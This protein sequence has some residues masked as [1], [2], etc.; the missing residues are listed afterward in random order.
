MGRGRPKSNRFSLSSLKGL[1]D[2]IREI[3]R[4][5][6]I[7]G[8]GYH[9]LTKHPGLY[10]ALYHHGISQKKLISRLGLDASYSKHRFKT[11]RSRS[12]AGVVIRRWDWPRILRVVS[13][14]RK[15]IGHLPPA[16]WFQRNKLGGLVQSVYSLGMSWGDLRDHF[17]DET[18]STFF[19]SRNGMRWRSRA[20]AGFS[21]YLHSRGVQ[22]E[23]GQRYPTAYADFAQ[24]AFGQYDVRLKS[25]RGKWIDV[26]IWGDKPL[27]HNPVGYAR[28]RRQK[29]AFNRKFNRNFLGLQYQDCYSDTALKKLLS[30]HIGIRKPLKSRFLKA[31]DPHIE[32]AHWSNV[33][34]LVATCQKIADLQ[35]DGK[36]PSEEWLRKRG[37]FANRTGVSYNTVS[38][39]I[40]HWVGGIRKLRELM[41]QPENSTLRW[42]RESALRELARWFKQY[43]LS[44]VTI[45]NEV[46][47]GERT[48]AR[49]ELE[50]GRK[51]NT[52]VTVYA[53]GMLKACTKL[54]LPAGFEVW[55]RTRALSELKIWIKTYGKA[56]AAVKHMALKGKMNVDRKELNRGL[57]I[58]SAVYKHVGSMSK[59]IERVS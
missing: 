16:A 33:D 55:S 34:E 51:I 58:N 10:F 37:K 8:L 26:E 12:K 7:Q 29:E 57:R 31:Y 54:G 53:G 20:E 15:R 32:T 48:L 47:R 14:E 1:L 11:W 52:A 59:A 9:R 44:P 49:K 21:N 40:Q 19:I 27:G 45:R 22:H 43:G 39:Y 36:F 42:T 17:K 50:R 13:R 18:Q 23:R 3:Y 25:S 41:G 46:A 24:R 4:N 2:Y 5:E 6:G 35:P 30:P 28:K 38:I 56:P